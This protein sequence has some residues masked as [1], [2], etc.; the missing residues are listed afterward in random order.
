MKKVS[1]DKEGKKWTERR[2]FVQRKQLQLNIPMTRIG[3]CF[4][5]SSRKLVALWGGN[6]VTNS[7]PICKKDKSTKKSSSSC[8]KQWSRSTAVPKLLPRL[9]TML[10]GATL[11]GIPSGFFSKNF[12][13]RTTCCRFYEMERCRNC[14]A[15]SE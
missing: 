15:T 4:P 6:V 7:F 2:E 11:Q 13:E 3:M 10:P 8:V 14:K 1:K 12:F 5:T 9:W